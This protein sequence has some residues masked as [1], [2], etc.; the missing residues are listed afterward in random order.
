MDKESIIRLLLLFI[1]I[2]SGVL[3]TQWLGNKLAQKKWEN[4]RRIGFRTEMAKTNTIL[5]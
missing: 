4:R 5:A 3:F 1:A 2:V